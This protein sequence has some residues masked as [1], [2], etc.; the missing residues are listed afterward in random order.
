MQLRN[1]DRFSFNQHY[2]LCHE[3]YYKQR[4]KKKNKCN[5][6]TFYEDFEENDSCN[7]ISYHLSQIYV[8]VTCKYVSTRSSNLFADNI[9]NIKC[10]F[11]EESKIV[12]IQ[13]K[14]QNWKSHA[15]SFP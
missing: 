11:K 10:G 15:K 6:W 2:E 7:G 13:E 12:K 14:T 3:F 8:C 5:V 9:F 4:N 1:S